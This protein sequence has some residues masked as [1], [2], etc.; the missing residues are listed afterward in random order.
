MKIKTPI[1]KAGLR[2]HF[3]YS[4]WKYLL[5]V[6]ASIFG[7]NLL[8]TTTAYRSPEHLRVDVYMQSTTATEEK[9]NAF[10]KNIWDACIPDMET[11]SPVI[12]TSTT[13]DYYGSMQLSVY[14]MAA[15]GDLY[16]LNTADF[17]TYAAQGVFLDLAPFIES[18]ELDVDGIDLAAGNVAIADDEGV[19]TAQ[20]GQF[21]IPLYSLYGYMDGMLLDNRDMIIGVTAFNG[22]EENVLK[23]LN[24]FLQAGRD[25]KPEW[26]NQ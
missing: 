9:V 15:E 26:M 19:P 14:M 12:L 21:G 20:M 10:F 23:F 8:Y 18:G 11:V 25:E 3:T 17:K 2:T 1:T 13:E 24:G 4:S 7:W 5:I 22:N 16:I 6:A